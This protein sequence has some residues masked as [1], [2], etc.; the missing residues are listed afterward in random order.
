ME[1]REAIKVLEKLHAS[2][3]ADAEHK[4]KRLADVNK[5]YAEGDYE[6]DTIAA[7]KHYTERAVTSRLE[8]EALSKAVMGLF[9]LEQLDK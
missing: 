7:I 9:R 3:V 2:K 4:E 1:Y 5:D 8:A 6:P